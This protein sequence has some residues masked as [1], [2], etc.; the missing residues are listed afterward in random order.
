MWQPEWIMVCLVRVTNESL[1]GPERLA[2][3][4]YYEKTAEN[5]TFVKN[6]FRGKLSERGGVYIKTLNYI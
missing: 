4:R 2:D 3:K 5:A 1:P 6:T